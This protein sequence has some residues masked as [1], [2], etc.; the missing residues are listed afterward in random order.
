MTFV[1]VERGAALL[2]GAAGAF[3]DATDVLG[4]AAG[5]VG[6][7]LLLTAGAALVTAV[8]LGRDD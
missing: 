4:G 8:L 3:V 1:Q 7:V 6:V 2:N 5:D